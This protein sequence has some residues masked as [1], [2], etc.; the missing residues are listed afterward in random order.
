MMFFILVLL[1]SIG[2]CNAHGLGECGY[3]D[4]L[5]KKFDFGEIP[6]SQ[7]RFCSNNRTVKIQYINVPMYFYNEMTNEEKK[8]NGDPHQ[9]PVHQLLRRCC[10][11]LDITEMPHLHTVQDLNL[12]NTDADFIFP[13]YSTASTEKM[14]GY[15][16]LPLIDI[17]DLMYASEPPKV[18]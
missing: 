8:Y 9:K 2:L 10:S 4:Y 1:S 15:H 16:Y 11:C 3:F 18:R 7:D 12:K 14:H 17:P 6:C 5:G 13:I